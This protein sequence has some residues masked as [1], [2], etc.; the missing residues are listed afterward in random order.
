[1]RSGLGAEVLGRPL[2]ESGRPQLADDTD[3]RTV[4]GLL[5]HSDPSLTMRTYAHVV[6]EA[7]RKATDRM[8]AFAEPQRGTP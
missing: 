3:P 1:M 4:A 5:G 6:N 8:G 7:A 2:S